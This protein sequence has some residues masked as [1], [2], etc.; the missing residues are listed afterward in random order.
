MPALNTKGFAMCH[1]S[2]TL[3]LYKKHKTHGLYRPML[4]QPKQS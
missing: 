2:A 1:P 3:A 4:L